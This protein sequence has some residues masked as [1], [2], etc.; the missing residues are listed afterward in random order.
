MKLSAHGYVIASWIL[1]IT[2]GITQ[3]YFGWFALVPGIF[4]IAAIIA[5]LLSA[6]EI[7]LA[8]EAEVVHQAPAEPVEIPR[9]HPAADSELNE[10][11]I[12]AFT[13]QLDINPPNGK[14]IDTR[15]LPYPK[16][17]IKR[18][19]FER[20]NSLEEGESRSL[21]IN[22]VVRLCSYQDG[23][24]KEDAVAL[25]GVSTMNMAPGKLEEMAD[26]ISANMERYNHFKPAA[27]AEMKEVIRYLQDHGLV[28]A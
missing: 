21:L 6:R 28:A 16:E 2:A 15:K 12:R 19:L 20:L 14:I 17:K 1:L 23:V 18:A 11:I 5:Y 24:G 8:T 3:V 13:H 26:K 25:G 9:R 7:Q 10:E 4:A 27:D 22:A